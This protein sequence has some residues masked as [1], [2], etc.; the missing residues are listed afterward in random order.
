M[1]FDQDLMR[2]A[3][4]VA[5]DYKGGAAQLAVDIGRKPSPKNTAASTTRTVC[6]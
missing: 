5:H 4:N 2:A 3:F 6:P 1:D